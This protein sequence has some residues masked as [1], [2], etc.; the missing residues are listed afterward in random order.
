MSEEKRKVTRKLPDGSFV[1]VK[2]SELVTGDEFT[3]TESDD[4]TPAHG[5]A[6]FRATGDAYVVD[7]GT[8]V[9]VWTID[10]YGVSQ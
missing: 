10:A 1:E 2:F 5:I 8:Y 4:G 3:L 6:L 9:G 7:R